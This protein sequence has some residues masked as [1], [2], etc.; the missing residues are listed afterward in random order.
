MNTTQ[1]KEQCFLNYNKEGS[2]HIYY[3]PTNSCSQEIISIISQLSK[4]LVNQKQRRGQS[5]DKPLGSHFFNEQSRDWLSCCHLQV[6]RGR[7]SYP[8]ATEWKQHELATQLP[9]F[10]GQRAKTGYPVATLLSTNPYWLLGCHAIDRVGTGL[11]YRKTITQICL[12]PISSLQ[13][14]VACSIVRRNSSNR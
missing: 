6:E 13:T 5:Q 2:V 1:Y 11:N 7:T 4:G 3:T 9:H 8:F 14:V 10:C 12:Q